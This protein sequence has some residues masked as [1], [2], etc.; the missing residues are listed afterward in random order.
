MHKYIYHHITVKSSVHVT[1]L[2]LT[3][4]FCL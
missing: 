4:P 1:T 2:F 3:L